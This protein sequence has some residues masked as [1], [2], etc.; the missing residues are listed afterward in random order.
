MRF[1]EGKIS[2]RIQ[3]GP[4]DLS[5]FRTYVPSFI[6]KNRGNWGLRAANLRLK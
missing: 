4:P 3:L 2:E 5:C 1:V 6:E